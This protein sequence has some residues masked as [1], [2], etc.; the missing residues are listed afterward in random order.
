MKALG[1]LDLNI[2]AAVIDDERLARLRLSRLLAGIGIDVIEEGK[3]GKDA[4]ALANNP[5]VD[6]LLLDINMPEMSGI[7]AAESIAE[8]G[9]SAPSIIFCTAYAEHAVD[10][11]ATQ[12]VA[13]LLKPVSQEALVKAIGKATQ[14]NRLQQLNFHSNEAVKAKVLTTEGGAKQ[15]LEFDEIL[16]FYSEEKLVFAKLLDGASVHVD[17]TLKQLE[18]DYENY[19]L[20][21]HRATLVNRS[22]MR[23]LYRDSAGCTK[24][25]LGNL[26]AA[27]ELDDDSV[28]VSRRHTAVVKKCFEEV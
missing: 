2:K 5:D 20:R 4:I 23:R 17:K 9:D 25:Q 11:F 3:S 15:T 1:S 14:L 8:L 27:T 24:L 18:T 12:A 6:L 16:Y 10:A 13:Y 7:Q 26:H 21:V 19:I 28:L 22:M